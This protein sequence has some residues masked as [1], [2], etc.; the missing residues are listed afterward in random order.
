[1]L[2]CSGECTSLTTYVAFLNIKCYFRYSFVHIVW[3]LKN[4]KADDTTHKLPLERNE[5]TV[6]LCSVLEVAP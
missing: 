4:I 5:L 3:Y 2:T 6:N 1:M